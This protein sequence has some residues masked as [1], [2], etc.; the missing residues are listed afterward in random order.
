MPR[1]AVRLLHAGSPS[2]HASFAEQE[3]KTD[4][5]ADPQSHR[6]KYLPLLWLPKYSQGHPHGRRRNGEALTNGDQVQQRAE[7]VRVHKKVVDL[8]R[9]FLDREVAAELDLHWLAP[10]HFAGGHADGLENILVASAAAGI[11]CDGFADLLV[12]RFCILVQQMKR[13]E[14]ETRRAVTALQPVAFRKRVLHRMKCAVRGKTFHG[15]DLAAICHRRKECAR[16]YGSAVHEDG[17]GAT[18]AGVATDVGS[19]QIQIL[20]QEVDEQRS[21]L[22]HRFSRPA[23]H[24]NPHPYFFSDRHIRVLPPH[25]HRGHAAGRL[26]SRVSP[27]QRPRHAY[28]PRYRAYHSAVPLLPALPRRRARWFARRSSGFAALFRLAW[29]ESRL[30]RRSLRR[31]ECPCR[32]PCL[33]A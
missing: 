22:N 2:L 13:G 18:I 10:P 12:G 19:R 25:A 28:S 3:C 32:C 17:A 23:I 7:A 14:K 27:T 20:S 30:G 4:R 29:H 6:R 21:R 24:T 26:Q 16:L 33:R 9:R 1:A 11:S 8:L 31:C 15:S 5:Q